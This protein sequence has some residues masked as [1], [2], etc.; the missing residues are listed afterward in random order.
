MDITLI[1]FSFF[2]GLG[3]FL[4]GI[5]AMSDGLQL[6]AGDKMRLI[7]EKGTSSPFRGVLT[8][9]LVTALIQSSSGTTVLTVG[10][11]NAGLLNLRQAI[12][13][14]MGANIGTTVTAY[15]I[16]FDLKDYA[17]PII[18]I[19]VFFVFF[20]KNKRLNY[21][22]QVIFG[23][24]L[25]FFGMDVMGQGMKPLRS[26]EFFI[27]LMT[28]VE[29]NALLGILIGGVFTA[30]VLSSSATTGIL[31]ELAYQGAVTLHQVVPILFGINIGT[32][33]TALLAGIG[34]TV[35]ARRAALSHFIFNF[36]GTLVF[37]PLF[38]TGIF[39]SLVIFITN[40]IYI[41][42]PGSGSWE[43]L[44]VKMQIAQIHGVFNIAN[45]LL[46][47]PFVAIMAA[48][49]TR[50]IPS[51]EGELD[52]AQQYLEPR[53]LNNP[54]LA[55]SNAKHELIRMGGIAFS[56]LENAIEFFYTGKDENQRTARSCE[57]VVD[58]LEREI[59]SYVLKA[60][61][62][63]N[64][65]SSLSQR[66]HT[67]MSALGDIERIGDHSQNIVELAE[68]ASAHGLTFS[69]SAMADL[70]KMTEHVK[71]IVLLSLEALE[72]EDKK[73]AQKVIEKDDIIDDM[74]KEL[75]KAHIA[76]I[77]AR[78]CYGNVGAVYLDMLSNLER[79]GDHSVNVAGYVIGNGS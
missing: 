7:L 77:N 30:I 27:N 42:I 74:E 34:A 41:L 11:V 5:K 43:T 57:M 39:L 37:L 73:L 18:A 70:E 28:N 31:Q 53:L 3:L 59:E 13:I 8:G 48:V 35:V 4:F 26:S 12:G 23:F 38:M 9:T 60:I 36:F 14:I 65:T 72:K 19:G 32:T 20:S 40:Y 61:S 56:S 2:G 67:I 10:L 22:G 64:L 49:V 21:F 45:T 16:G 71:E 58:K 44:N 69:D 68:Y 76:R 46:L 52:I 62:G 50:I 15:M 17:L 1:L 79:I 33:A 63:R 47:L 78:T 55:L 24:G 6:V 29:N 54:P 66:S 25:L 51:K 75:R